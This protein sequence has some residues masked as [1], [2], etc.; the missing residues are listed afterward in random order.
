MNLRWRV[1]VAT[2]VAATA[3]VH[4]S[5]VM[6]LDADQLSSGADRVVEA[7]VSAKTT[8][9]NSTHTGLETHVTLAV[10]ATIKGANDATVEIVVPGGELDGGRHVIVGMPSVDVGE[11]ARW[12][13]RDRGDGQLAVYG[14]AQGKWPAR[15]LD[16]ATVY[17]R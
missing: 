5:T 4:A 14:W 8:T 10:S 3:Q 16:G 6:Q 17:M 2:I 15:M 12:F 1:A 9:W 7:I 13:L 11:R